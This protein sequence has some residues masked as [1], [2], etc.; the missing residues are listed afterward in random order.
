M[1]RGALSEEFSL[2]D[3][4][5][6]RIAL[7]YCFVKLNAPGHLWLPLNRDYKPLGFSR[8]VRVDYSEYAKHAIRFARDPDT[9]TDTWVAEDAS[10]DLPKKWIHKLPQSYEDYFA[11]LAIICKRAKRPNAAQIHAC[12]G[13]EPQ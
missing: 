3:N 9:F 4:P 10:G 7:P 1:Q 6:V 11:R 13:R 5:F 2:L 12:L 8:D